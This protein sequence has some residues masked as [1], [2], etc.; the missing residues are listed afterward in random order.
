[1]AAD[2]AAVASSLGWTPVPSGANFAQ[3]VPFDEGVWYGTQQ[4]DGDPVVS[5]VQLFLGLASFKGRGGEA[6]TAIL[7]QRLRPRW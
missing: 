6:A 2:P 5:D 4:V 3:L 7:E 1:M